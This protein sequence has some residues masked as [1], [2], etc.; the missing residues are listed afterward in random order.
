MA[1]GA[2]VAD[3]AGGASMFAG[4]VIG[5]NGPCGTDCATS[6]GG[7]GVAGVGGASAAYRLAGCG[8]CIGCCVDGSS[9]NE[10]EKTIRCICSC[11]YC[12]DKSKCFL[13]WRES[14][15]RLV[16]CSNGNAMEFIDKGW[17]MNSTRQPVDF[18]QTKLVAISE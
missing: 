12:I 7:F 5:A 6:L 1:T 8:G 13:L 15:I 2:S 17:K 3:A 9:G 11:C 16:F 10:K 14:K 18:N 4:G